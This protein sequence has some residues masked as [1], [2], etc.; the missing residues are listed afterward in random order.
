MDIATLS[1]NMDKDPSPYINEFRK[2]ISSFE[3]L[4]NLNKQP[5]KLI[6]RKSVV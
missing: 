3:H 4:L 5:E 2:Q 6:D 1:I